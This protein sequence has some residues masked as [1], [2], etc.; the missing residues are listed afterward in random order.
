MGIGKA[1]GSTLVITPTFNER[2]NVGGLVETLFRLYP[3]IRFLIVDDHSPDGTADVVRQL[4]ARYPNLLLLERAGAASFA[5]SYLDGF[6]FALD[7]AWCGAVVTMDADFSHDPLAI[8]RLLDGL[9]AADVVIGSRYTKGGSVR[10]W[11]LPRRILSKGG[12]LYVR[13]VLGLTPKDAT[14]GFMAIRREMLALAPLGEMVSDGY[15]FLVELK[16]LLVRAGARMAEHPIRFDERRE[17][18]SKMSVGKI[19]ESA[20]LPWRIR[21]R[22]GAAGKGAARQAGQSAAEGRQPGE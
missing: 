21:V 11:N 15:A 12:N 5:R 1:T 14:A 8:G 7:Q 6:R 22:W 17:G 4:Q 18:Q 13:T 16:Y 19:R 2:E 20:L 3:D 9:A 10:N